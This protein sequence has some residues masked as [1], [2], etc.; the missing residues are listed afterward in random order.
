MAALGEPLISYKKSIEAQFK[1]LKAACA[2]T[3][4]D[5]PPRLT[6]ELQKW[7][8]Q[9]TNVGV[10]LG[11]RLYRTKSLENRQPCPCLVVLSKCVSTAICIFLVVKKKFYQTQGAN[12]LLELILLRTVFAKVIVCG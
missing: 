11:M 7:L 8:A 5:L 4:T 12:I 2:P 9:S 1:A 6:P 10:E 3:G